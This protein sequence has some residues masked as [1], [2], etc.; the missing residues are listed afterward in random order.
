MRCWGHTSLGELCAGG[1]GQSVAGHSGGPC[2]RSIREAGHVQA[3]GCEKAETMGTGRRDRV[4]RPLESKIS[5]RGAGSD[6]PNSFIFEGSVVGASWV[7]SQWGG[8]ST[9]V[10]GPDGCTLQDGK[11]L[12]LLVTWSVWGTPDSSVTMRSAALQVQRARAADP[13]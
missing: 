5:S 8:W 1:R 6:S 11:A 12:H 7:G 9:P 13:E 3:R 4:R 2:G 10:W